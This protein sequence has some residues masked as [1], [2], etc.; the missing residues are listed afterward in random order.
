[1]RPLKKQ[2]DRK[3]SPWELVDFVNHYVT[4]LPK[5]SQWAQLACSEQYDI[6]PSTENEPVRLTGSLSRE[7]EPVSSTGS[8]S[9]E[10]EPVS[11]T[12]SL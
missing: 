4:S 6:R 3:L 1:M 12:C 2:V 8:F 7:S 9:G 5:A 11:L 10:C